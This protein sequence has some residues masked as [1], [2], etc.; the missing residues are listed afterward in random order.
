MEGKAFKKIFWP[1]N[2]WPLNHSDPGNS[3]KPDLKIKQHKYEKKL[4]KNS[5]AVIL[6]RIQNMQN[7]FRRMAKQIEATR[8]I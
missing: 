3:R 5:V 8:K 1:F 7:S 4:V 2:S 6:Q